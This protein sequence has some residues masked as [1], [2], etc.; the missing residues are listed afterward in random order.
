MSI[1]LGLHRTT[2]TVFQCEIHSL[3][4]TPSIPEAARIHRKRGLGGRRKITSLVTY[5]RTISN[6]FTRVSLED[7]ECKTRMYVKLIMISLS[8]THTHTR[9][10]IHT[11]HTRTHT[12]THTPHTRA[13]THIHTH[14]T[15]TYTHTHHIHTHTHTQS[16]V[17]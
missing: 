6:R 3:I 2:T 1:Y 16:F 13:H 7:P 4:S 17:C 9:A 8:Q 12:H 5:H 10:N 15:H 11:H 14:H